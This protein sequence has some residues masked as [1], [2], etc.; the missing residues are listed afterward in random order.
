MKHAKSRPLSHTAAPSRKTPQRMDPIESVQL[1]RIAQDSPCLGCMSRRGFL[2][3]LAGVAGAASLMSLKSA[4]MYLAMRSLM[5]PHQAQ[6]TTI[7]CLGGFYSGHMEAYPC[8]GHFQLNNDGWVGA[9]EADL[10]STFTMRLM[11]SLV[12]R[13]GYISDPVI[14]TAITGWQCN[15][16]ARSWDSNSLKK[17]EAHAMGLR[18]SAGTR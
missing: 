15:R 12:R 14:D 4:A 5:D 11:N 2:H 3:S 16:S 10:Q 7:N 13:P 17:P 9:C 6:V 18:L 8:L 1:F